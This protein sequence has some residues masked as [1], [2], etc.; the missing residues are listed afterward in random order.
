M[1]VNKINNFNNGYNKNIYVKC[2]QQKAPLFT[3]NNEDDSKRITELQ[4][5]IN[6]SSV[7]VP[8]S[9]VKTGVQ[10]LPYGLKAHFYKLSNGQKVVILPKEGKTV[11]RSYVNTG[12]LNEPDN[13]RGISH[14]IE[15]NLFNGSDGLEAGEFFNATD[16]IGADTNASTGMAET[17]Y[18]I[19]SHLLNEGDLENEIKIHA[20]MLETPKFALDML[21]KEK[22]IVNSEINMITSDP[23]NIAFNNTIKQLFN[24]QTSSN[25]VIAGTTDNITN[26]TRD[27]VVNYFNNNYYP[28][29]MV[30]VV[31]GEIEPENTMKLISKYF[32]SNKMPPKTRHF[33]KLIPIEKTVRQD[34]ISDRTKSPYLVMGFK[35]PENNNVKDLIYTTALSQ[36]MFGSSDADKI[37]KKLNANVGSM[38]EKILS[39][40][41]APKALMIMGEA[42]E[43]NSEVMLRKIYGQIHKQQTRL[44]SDEDLAIVKR[45]MKKSFVQ[46]FESSFTI[47]DFIGTSLLEGRANTINEYE[48]IIDEMTPQDLQ[49][50]AK[51]YFD[52]NKAAITMLHPSQTNVETL[53]NNY[54]KSQNI[55]FTGTVKKQAYKLDDVKQYRLP[56]NYNVV[57][58]NSN[59]P[60][61]YA[62]YM[63][64]S[65]SP[66]IPK[67][68]A[69]FAVLN[70]I[71]ENGTMNKTLEEFSRQ[72]EKA[73]I[74]AGIETNIDGIIGTFNCDVKDFDKGNALFRELLDNPRFTQE[75]FDKAVKDIDDRILRSEKSPMDKL[76]PELNK[77]SHTKQ[78]IREGLKTLTLDEVKQTYNELTKNAQGLTSFAAPYNSNPEIKTKI[79]NSVAGLKPVNPYI[80]ALTDDF[81]PIKESKVLTEAD[82]KNQA[83]I[84]MAYKYQSNG[85]IK[86]E[87]AIRL[88]NIILGGGPSSRLFSDLREKQKLAYAVR[89]AVSRKNTTGTML[90]T[91]GTTTDNKA[92]GEQSFD[93]L[94]K[95]INGFKYNIDKIT[96]EKVTQEELDKAKLTLKNDILSANERTRSKNIT[97]L[98]GASGWYGVDETNKLLE[99]T[100][101]I[102]AEDIYNAANN[103]FGGK[104]IYSIV[105]TQDT[106]DYNKDYLNNLIN[107]LKN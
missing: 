71:L 11:L 77:Y 24:I 104:P 14:Y 67:N 61:I 58:Y 23:E 70:E 62:N 73:G 60:D 39:K 30:T 36:L 96:N 88:L 94:Q 41:D 1:T 64:K 68:P 91:I 10:D 63:I 34:I 106:L 101:T 103:I 7:K 13:I 47:N 50:A 31:S 18:F 20:S 37:F 16:K 82:N 5:T 100:D 8:L 95:S 53:N 15:H 17:N 99:I 79:F 21:E 65:K 51:K 85:N 38:Q 9:Y 22:G 97:V 76:K 83:K 56:N 69:T 57:T 54:N 42:S 89:S 105:A 86:D 52:L 107:Q 32:S 74:I 98:G 43:E 44:V 81:E 59:L 78:E 93:N 12:S 19:S 84:I 40:P 87:A 46:M 25:D 55:S 80:P 3:A 90:L 66:V 33:E 6:D 102:T 28:A 35:G 49:N 2:A 72:A 92:T 27:D 45:D 75:T 48:K 26:L 29:N 4:N